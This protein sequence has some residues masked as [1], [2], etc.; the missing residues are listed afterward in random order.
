MELRLA[1]LLMVFSVGAPSAAHACLCETVTLPGQI[2]QPRSWSA[3][4][5]IFIA[6]VLE[7]D[8]TGAQSPRLTVRFVTESSWRGPLPD[9]VTLRVGSNAPCAEYI[10]G[11][12]YL[13]LADVEVT[14]DSALVTGQCDYAWGIHFPATLRMLAELG[15]PDWTAPQLGS[16]AIDSH[17]VRLGSPIVRSASAD[18]I[19]FVTPRQADIRRF[20]IADWAAP[21]AGG[22][23]ILYLPPGLYQFRITWTDGTTYESY[24]SLRC[25]RPVSGSSCQVHRFFGLLR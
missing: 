25:D 7:V 11:G 12:R 1:A 4:P 23:R 13:V 5:S 17:A 18:S 10:A 3:R 9:T 21:Y 8:E 6:H 14:S 22:S 15:P 20:E 19:V 2:P 24:L 16:R